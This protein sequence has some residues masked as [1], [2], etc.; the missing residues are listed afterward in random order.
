MRCSE[1]TQL[2]E[3]SLGKLHAKIVHNNSIKKENLT[4]KVVEL[5]LGFINTLGHRN[6]LRAK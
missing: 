6:K 2:T 5:S 4:S 1:K 3:A